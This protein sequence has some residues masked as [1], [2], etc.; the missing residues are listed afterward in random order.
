SEDAADDLD[1]LTRLGER[2]P[3]GLAVPALDDLRAGEP[4]AEQEAPAGHEV[5][6]CGGHRGIRRRSG[7]HLED[8][9]ADLQRG[10]RRREPGEHGGRV[11][12]PRFRSPGR[13]VTEALG[14]VR[15]LHQLRRIR[16]GRRIPHVEAEPHAYDAKPMAVT[17]LAPSEEIQELRAR[18][19][20]LMEEHVYR[21]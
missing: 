11:G 15:E 19:R 10:R 7:R 5:E 18:Y 9:R 2:L 1:I 14:F 4:E 21:H 20:A 3:P 8:R 17:E 13:V 6:R 12:S 16:P